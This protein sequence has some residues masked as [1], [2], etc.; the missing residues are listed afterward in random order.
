MC[1]IGVGRT[2]TL[3]HRTYILVLDIVALVTMT[4]QTSASTGSKESKEN[5]GNFWKDLEA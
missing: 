5:E 3:R 1:Y 2:I 4:D